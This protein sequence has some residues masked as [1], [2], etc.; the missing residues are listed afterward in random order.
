MIQLARL[1]GCVMLRLRFGRISLRLSVKQIAFGAFLFFGVVTVL[2]YLDVSAYLDRV[3]SSKHSSFATHASPLSPLVPSSPSS[4][5]VETPS[6]TTKP[7]VV[8]KPPPATRPDINDQ[9][10]PRPFPRDSPPLPSSDTH[11][12]LVVHIQQ[13]PSDTHVPF[14]VYIQQQRQEM[15]HDR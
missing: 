3:A 2:T 8:P 9:V 7:F 10:P 6:P 15:A 13:R 11:V 5:P 1:I 12:P 14:A 4:G